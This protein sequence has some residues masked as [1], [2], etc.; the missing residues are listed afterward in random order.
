M[1]MS[2]IFR[3][4][5]CFDANIMKS[6]VEIVTDSPTYP[7][8]K[9]LKVMCPKCNHTTVDLLIMGEMSFCSVCQEGLEFCPFDNCIKKM[10]KVYDLPNV[11]LTQDLK[12]KCKECGSNDINPVRVYGEYSRSGTLGDRRWILDVCRACGWYSY[13]TAERGQMS[14]CIDC[15]GFKTR[16]GTGE[17]DNPTWCPFTYCGGWESLKR[18]YKMKDGKLADETFS[19][20]SKE[21]VVVKQSGEICYNKDN[22]TSVVT[23]IPMKRELVFSEMVNVKKKSS[24]KKRTKKVA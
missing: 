5:K 6:N 1:N 22:T 3:C 21:L 13:R 16:W 4:K 2:A 11:S 12:A 9:W 24:P 7:D 15:K 17:G 20:P 23:V 8:L 10:V 19:Y 14:G 18:M